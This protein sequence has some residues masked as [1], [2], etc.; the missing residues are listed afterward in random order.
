MLQVGYFNPFL[1]AYELQQTKLS[2]EL[3]KEQ[4]WVRL[5]DAY[6]RKLMGESRDRELNS[7]DESMKASAASKNFMSE[8]NYAGRKE[9]LRIPQNSISYSQNQS[10]KVLTHKASGKKRN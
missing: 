9:A 7:R 10:P 4:I 3:T 2:E 8:Q 5:D 6:R 1:L